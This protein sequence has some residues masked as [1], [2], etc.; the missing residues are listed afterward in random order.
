MLNGL[1]PFVQPFRGAFGTEWAGKN[2]VLDKCCRHLVEHQGKAN[3]AAEPF[4]KMMDKKFS[5]GTDLFYSDSTYVE[6]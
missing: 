1:F 2:R 4:I 6:N 5:L 3:V